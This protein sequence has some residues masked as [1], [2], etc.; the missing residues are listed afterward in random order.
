MRGRASGGEMKLLK[1]EAMRGFAA[2]YVVLHHVVPHELYFQGINFGHLFRFGQE[3]VI[4]FFL[5][6]GFVINYSYANSKDK[7]FG[8][9]FFN[10]AT[11]IYIPLLVV[12]A[13]GYI[14]ECFRVAAL[15]DPEIKDLVL[16]ILMFQDM[17]ALKPNVIVSSYMHN[18]PLWS[19]SYE[20]W[21]YML[22]FPIV[23]L[24]KTPRTAALL[25]FGLSIASALLYIVWPTF[26]PR[27]LMYMAIWWS[28]AHLAQAWID[29]VGKL[30]LKDFL[31]PVAGIGAIC[32]VLAVDNLLHRAGGG[33]LTFGVHPF[34]ELR[35]FAF[36]LVVLVGAYVWMKARWV[37]FDRVF[38]L[39]VLAAPI[40]YSIYISHK[41]LVANATYLAFLNS[42][43]LEF[44]LYCAVMVVFCI[45]LEIYL[46]PWARRA[47]RPL[48]FGRHAQTVGSGDRKTG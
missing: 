3:A 46:Y 28:G 38:G 12:Y 2:L 45:V 31:L 10:R 41:Y 40:S 33:K 35:H 21:F 16:N 19:L 13:L 5:V 34:L 47:L 11:R 8:L 42:P 39:F 14:I 44:A 4:L 26:V 22:F 27:L 15:A 17:S 1:L 23:T 48:V 18:T 6:S 36:S 30:D 24:I 43:I 9:Y 32:A 20:W 37:L 25:V 29:K 7:S